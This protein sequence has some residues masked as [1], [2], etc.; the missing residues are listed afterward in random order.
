M[1]V[2][3]LLNSIGWNRRALTLE[4]FEALCAQLGV[5]VLTL[6]SPIEGF[7]THY[8]ARPVIVLSQS[9]TDQQ[10]T[11]IAWHEL[12]HHLLHHPGIA[13]FDHTSTSK[14]ERQANII[15]ACALIPQTIIR[16][17]EFSVI[18]DE[19]NVSREVV[20]LRAQIWQLL[21]L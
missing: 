2:P 10:R 6:A 13:L 3:S 12:A 20:L 9:L 8:R 11:F 7:Y 21:R 4:D 18:E 5:T 1:Q 15:A 17:C 14:A 19:F 16:A